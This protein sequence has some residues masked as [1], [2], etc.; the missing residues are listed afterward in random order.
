[1]QGTSLPSK[2][3]VM[4]LTVWRCISA[5]I[6]LAPALLALVR[7]SWTTEAGSM[8][9]I[10]IL[11][12]VWTI[13]NALR[14]RP[15]GQVETSG[16][17][18]IWIALMVPILCVY[19]FAQAIQ[20]TALMAMAAW[21]GMVATLYGWF[22]GAAIRRCAVPLL[23][24]ALCVP[25]PYALSVTLNA[26]LRNWTSEQAV[27]LADTFGLDAAIGQGD[28]IMGP[29]VLAVENACAGTS[30]TLSLVAI[31]VLYAY[32]MRKAGPVTV[33]G[34]IALA[35]PIALVA[36][37]FRVVGLLGLVSAFGAS[38]LDTVIHPLSGVLSF[39]IAA[40]LLAVTA[41]VF[42]RLFRR[43]RIA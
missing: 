1:M 12:G 27:R 19:V 6:F 16:S 20:M 43:E 41:G 4:P 31:G 38:V 28:V 30:T 13:Y 22:G 40:V 36:N 23:F 14:T 17:L 26:K 9:P 2:T 24:T 3:Q 11:L 8:A 33:L 10:V 21:C 5:L 39:G 15:G 32:W 25:L 37:I 42:S 35:V 34:V 29:Y 7:E 18:G